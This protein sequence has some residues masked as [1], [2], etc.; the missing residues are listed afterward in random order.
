MSSPFED[1]K[2]GALHTQLGIDDTKKIPISML[3]RIMQAELGTKIATKAGEVTV[4]AQLKKRANFA[5]N[6]GGWNK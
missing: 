4:T 2:K 5:M 1:I 6:A 3:H